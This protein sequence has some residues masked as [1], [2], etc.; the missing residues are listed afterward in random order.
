M[1]ERDRRELSGSGAGWCD[2]AMC[3]APIMMRSH[4]S[5]GGGVGQW[6]ARVC[7]NKGNHTWIWGMAFL[8]MLQNG[9][10]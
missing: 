4:G 8:G 2:L 1:L 3:N 7:E 9:E 6:W 5:V 10:G